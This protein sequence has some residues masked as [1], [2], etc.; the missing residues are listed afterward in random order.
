MKVLVT[1]VLFNYPQGNL[2]EVF[3]DEAAAWRRVMGEIDEHARDPR[4]ARFSRHDQPDDTPKARLEAWNYHA[5]AAMDP[6]LIEVHP[7]EEVQT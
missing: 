6:Y 2:V 4:H 3:A 7:G 1:V 5:C